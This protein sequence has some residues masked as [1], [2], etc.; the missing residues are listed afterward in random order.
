MLVVIYN[1]TKKNVDIKNNN[2]ITEKMKEKEIEIIEGQ[3]K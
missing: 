2:K 3:R 1:I